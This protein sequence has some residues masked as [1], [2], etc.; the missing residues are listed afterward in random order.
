MGLK[1]LLD[2]RTDLQLALGNRGFDEPRIDGWV[3]VGLQD[4]LSQHEFEEMEGN[5]SVGM[6]AHIG[7]FEPASAQGIIA[8][9]NE[10]DKISMTRISESAFQRLEFNF[11]G[12][13]K[14]WVRR[15]LDLI[16]VWPTPAV[17]T[18]IKYDIQNTEDVLVGDGA[19]TDLQS[20]WDRA[21]H[22]LAMAHALTDL[23]E[24]ERSIFFFN[25]ASRYIAKR[26]DLSKVDGRST[27]E[28]VKILDSFE[29]LRRQRE[30]DTELG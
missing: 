20:M 7:F 21:V 4:L 2:F 16:W 18:S 27:G 5:F 14:F 22:L 25:G 10:T 17:A 29:Q 13:P 6:T 24:A 8:M 1:T 9:S 28:P 30:F 19:T 26:I 11:E 3:N 23:E 15:G 12:K